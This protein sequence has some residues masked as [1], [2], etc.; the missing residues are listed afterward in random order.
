M[1][2]LEHANVAAVDTEGL[3][4]FLAAAFPDFQVRGQGVDQGGRPWR[5]VGND[6]FYLAISTVPEHTGRKPYSDATGLNHLGWEVDDVAALEARMLEAGYK[7]NLKINDHPA[8][9]RIYFY[10]PDGNDW[11]FVEY[12]TDDLTQRNDYTHNDHT[13]T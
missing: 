7:P 6:E 5:H 11:E 10:D 9:K 8:R 4:H 1:M 13:Q 3:T 2:K 12:L